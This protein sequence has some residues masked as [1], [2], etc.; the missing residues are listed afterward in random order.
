MLQLFMGGGQ[1][2]KNVNAGTTDCSALL[3]VLT[4]CKKLKVPQ[5]AKMLADK[6]KHLSCS[7]SL[8]GAWCIKLLPNGYI[9]WEWLVFAMHPARY[10]RGVHKDS[11]KFSLLHHL[12]G[13]Q[14]QNILQQIAL[15][16]STV[17]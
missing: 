16:L 13:E 8:A 4:K 15:E 3:E 11:G 1:K 9:C 17:W 6:V 2:D 5:D 10:L 7:R 14:C 12:L